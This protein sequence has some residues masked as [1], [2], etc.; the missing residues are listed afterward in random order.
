MEERPK[1]KGAQLIEQLMQQLP[2]ESERYKVLASAKRFKSS[3]VELGEWLGRVSTAS[4]FQEW[5]YTSFEDYCSKEIRIRRQTAEK[6]LLAYRFMEREEPRLLESHGDRPLPDYRSMDL[7]R[8][9]REEQRFSQN[10]YDELRKTVIDEER[11]HPIVAKQFRDIAQNYQPDQQANRR[12][13][14]ALSAA[15]RLS[16]S[17]ME[18]DDIPAEFSQSL[19]GLIGLLEDRVEED[20]VRSEG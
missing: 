8:K 6:L 3:W 1:S 19:G 7:L 10:E 12:C 15:R 5:G 18:I 2:P 16:T 20:D 4:Q 14:T 17:L 11:S 13:K 9:A